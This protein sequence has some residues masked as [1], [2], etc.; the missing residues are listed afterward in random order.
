MSKVNI[1]SAEQDPS[2]QK[3]NVNNIIVELPKKPP[4]TG[5]AKGTW[6]NIK[7]KYTD[8]NGKQ[9]NIKIQTS[10]LFSYGISKFDE[11]SPNKMSLAMVTRRLREAQANNEDLSETDLVDIKVEDETIK[12]LEDITE[13]VKELMMEP[14]MIKAL[15]KK[16]DKKWGSFVDDME[17][18][19]R[20]SNDQGVDSVY[21]NAK[22]VE[23]V[24]F[25]KTK[26]LIIDENEDEGVRELNQK[27]TIA[28]LSDKDCNCKATFILVIDSVFVGTAPYLQVK[29]SEVVIGEFIEFKA[30]RAIIIPNR[31]RNRSRDKKINDNLYD[32]DE[33]DTEPMK[34]KKIIKNSD[35]DSN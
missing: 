14:E 26:F 2:F 28:K 21:V 9:E 22:V 29:V 6:V 24:K 18:V 35:S 17:I 7:Y 31:F 15:G 11:T 25:M 3:L 10:E 33:D 23:D 5:K 19:K 16:T 8:G 30:K 20:K 1:I 34:T 13:K 12:I 27:E 4:T 32:S